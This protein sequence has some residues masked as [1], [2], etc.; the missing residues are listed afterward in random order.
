M[1]RHRDQAS[2][3][4]RLVFPSVQSIQK[5][6]QAFCLCLA[7]RVQEAPRKERDYADGERR[8]EPERPWWFVGPLL[9]LHGEQER[10]G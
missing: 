10:L 6:I 1:I 2:I 5:S 9:C 4:L 8:G 7:E 3:P